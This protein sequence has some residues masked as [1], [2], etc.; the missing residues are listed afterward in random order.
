MTPPLGCASPVVVT[1]GAGLVGRE[2][3]RLL[4]AEGCRDIRIVDLQSV[5][6]PLGEPVRAHRL[7]LRCDDL[8][9]AFTGAETVFH[10]AACQYHS[11]LAPTTYGLPFASVNV[12]GTRRTLAAARQAGA[13][14]FVH[15]SSS[16][17]YGLPLHSPMREDHPRRPLGPYGHSKLRAETLVEEAH[18]HGLATAIVRP[19]PIFGPGRTGAITRLFDDILAGR[20]VTLIGHGGNRQDL[21]SPED[22][23]QLVVLAGGARQGHAVY[24]CGSASA[25]TMREW[26]DALIAEAGSRSAI[27]GVPAAAAKGAL[28]LLELARLAPVRREQ[29]AIAD[30]DYWLDTSV[31]R[32]RLGWVPLRSGV[33]AALAMFRWY[34][35]R[36]R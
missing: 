20:P 24:N 34:R 25:A 7:D 6:V 4:V 29:Y 11:P 31:A 26:L 13:T 27:R 5:A 2:V 32:S 12:E 16:M 22:C 36:D 19:G 18:A 28:R 17:V 15:V 14:T 10:L 23:A 35:A 1:G 30:L 8:A 21:V 3:V 9:P 33:D